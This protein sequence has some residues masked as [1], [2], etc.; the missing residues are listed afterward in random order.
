[1]S[2]EAFTHQKIELFWRNYRIYNLRPHAIHEGEHKLSTIIMKN[3]FRTD[4]I[5]K[6]R[7]VIGKLNDMSI[8]KIINIPY[9]AGARVVAIANVRKK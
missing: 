3:G 7:H 6:I 8:S 9:I 5:C 1:M 4:T 2:G